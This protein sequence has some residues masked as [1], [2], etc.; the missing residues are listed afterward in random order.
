[1]IVILRAFRAELSIGD[2]TLFSTA[3]ASVQGALSSLVFAT[4]SSQEIALFYSRYEQLASTPQPIVVSDHPVQPSPLRAGIEIENVS[5]R[6]SSGLPWILR[7]LSLSL[8]SAP[9]TALVGL[10]GAGKTTLVKLLT[11]M[12]DPTEGRI[13]WDGRDIRDFDV[14]ADR[15]P[16][17]AIAFGDIRKFE[18]CDFRKD[19]AMGLFSRE[20][21]QLGEALL[22]DS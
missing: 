6:Y 21:R 15:R 4:A 16:V 22:L 14:S 8:P 12:Y 9:S 5:F 18:A 1:M 7:D 17:G 20:S 13:T 11:R 19:G 10:N 2:V 3:V